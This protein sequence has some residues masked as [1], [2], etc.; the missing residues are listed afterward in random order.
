MRVNA[1]IKHL[2][3]I[4]ILL[5]L[6]VEFALFLLVLFLLC[7]T[8]STAYSA[9][10]LRGFINDL[11]HP[12]RLETC[13]RDGSISEKDHQFLHDLFEFAENRLKLQRGAS[14]DWAIQPDHWPSITMITASDTNDI[15][16]YF[17]SL[18]GHIDF[19]YLGFY[20]LEAAMNYKRELQRK[21]LAVSVGKVSG[22]S[23]GGWVP[24]PFIVP[25][26][27][28]KQGS[29]AELIL[30]ELAHRTWNNPG[31]L[32]LSEQFAS[33]VGREGAALFLEEH[34]GKESEEYNW[35]LQYCKNNDAAEAYAF[36]MIP[37]LKKQLTLP[38]NH[39]QY[40][41]NRQLF[42]HV[43]GQALLDTAMSRQARIKIASAVIAGRNAWFASRTT[44]NERNNEV[45]LFFK[46]RCD[47]KP[48]LLIDAFVNGRHQGTT[49]SK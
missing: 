36:R 40:M 32:V 22:F 31:N 33:V 14:Y 9:S 15:Q 42:N 44:Y 34:Y 5:F 3:R 16:P 21:G 2:P 25:W 13:L 11:R 29:L 10:Q 27:K 49:S 1:N 18:F 6:I 23:L 41:H 48:D 38:V 7:Y 37:F 47:S 20:S 17:H 12:A 30:H 39:P 28:Q 19:P 8:N 43:A 26:L 46:E 35:Y 4:R 45:Y 24:D